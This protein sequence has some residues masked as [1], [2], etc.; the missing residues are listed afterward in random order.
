[1]LSGT[2]LSCLVF[3]CLVLR[4]NPIKQS[5]DQ[6]IKSNQ[7]RPSNSR[8][9]PRVEIPE[10]NTQSAREGPFLLMAVCLSVC[11]SCVISS[12]L[13]SGF[14]FRGFCMQYRGE[15]SWGFQVPFF[16]P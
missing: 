15:R 2:V 7:S 13:L 8:S 5:S 1:M 11:L 9:G 12:R 6:A 10:A 14:L 4:R 16:L 3:V